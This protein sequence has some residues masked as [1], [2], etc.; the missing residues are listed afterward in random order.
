[1]SF[2]VKRSAVLWVVA[3]SLAPL[4]PASDATPSLSINDIAVSRLGASRVLAVFTVSLSAP[5][6]DTVAIE[7]F[8]IDGTALAGEDFE[9]TR[10][11]LRIPAGETSARIAVPVLPDSGGAERQFSV[12]I[13]SREVE[14][15][16]AV[17]VATILPDG[18]ER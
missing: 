8:T 11:A 4:A 7:F 13:H 1:M 15:A 9:H 2:S 17:G 14:G 18:G 10:G 5:S 16:D 12:S 3:L 6:L